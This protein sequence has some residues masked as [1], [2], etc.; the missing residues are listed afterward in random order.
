MY[1]I[2]NH[3][4][5]FYFLFTLFKKYFF[6]AQKENIWDWRNGLVVKSTSLADDQNWVP[7]T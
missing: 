5:S 1:L 7:S 4:S 2:V 3:Q 6:I